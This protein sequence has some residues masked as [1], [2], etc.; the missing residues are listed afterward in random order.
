MDERALLA[1]QA[2]PD[3]LAQAAY[4]RQATLEKIA[5]ANPT[6]TLALSQGKTMRVRKSARAHF[7]AEEEAAVRAKAQALGLTLG[8][9][10]RMASL[11]S[12]GVPYK[13]KAP[14]TKSRDQL[15][16]VLTVLGVQVKKLGT[17]INQLAHQA[18]AGMVPVSRKEIEYL[19][20][21]LQLLTSK[22]TA[23]VESILA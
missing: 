4:V 23:A 20:N 5:R 6:F 7:T 19:L 22:A 10:Q 11:T 12:A 16:H 3:G 15:L 9:F 2:G 8:E 14:R 1:G 18:N 13:D 21:G 17:N